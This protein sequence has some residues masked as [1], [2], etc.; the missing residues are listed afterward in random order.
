M[1][2]YRCQPV[3]KVISV[4]PPFLSGH[5]GIKTCMRK[6]RFYIK[7]MEGLKACS[8]SADV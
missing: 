6:E 3:G 2:A 4:A 7:P 5:R 8:F 1:S